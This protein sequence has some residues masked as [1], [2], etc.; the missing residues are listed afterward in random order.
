MKICSRLV[1]DG[2][3]FTLA[4]PYPRLAPGASLIGVGE[5]DAVSRVLKSKQLFRYGM[6]GYHAMSEAAKFEGKLAN[7]LRVQYALGVNSGTSGLE[8]ALRA[9][10][11]GEGD[12]VLVPIFGWVSNVSSIIKVGATP[13]FA[14]VDSTLSI[15]VSRIEN[16]VSDRTRAIMPIHMLGSACDMDSIRLFSERH[17]LLVIE[18][19]SQALGA[20]FKDGLVGALGDLGV[21]S[22][23]WNKMITSGEGGGVVTNK[24]ALYERS[25]ACH[26]VLGRVRNSLNPMDLD[27]IGNNFRM[28]EIAA[29]ILSVQL[30]R[31]EATITDLKRNKSLL[32]SHLNEFLDE[33]H[34]QYRSHNDEQGETGTDFV[35]IFPESESD[36]LPFIVCALRAEGL[37]VASYARDFHVATSWGELLNRSGVTVKQ[38]I[39]EMESLKI[40]DRAIR[41]PLNPLMDSCMLGQIAEVIKKVVRAA[42]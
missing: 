36:R 42:M 30:D 40:L 18:D 19:A 22:F 24:K 33:Y 5:E 20:K 16:N 38:N 11:I 35:L 37:P 6:D 26:D 39:E 25:L 9:A 7:Y 15:D 1:I 10:G 3:E 8:C 4:K 29:A 2:G 27:S 13:I 23:Q 34:I 32:K 12:E 41:L 28:T 31:V 21:L 14:D 17:G